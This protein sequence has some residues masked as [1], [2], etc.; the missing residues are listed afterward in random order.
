MSWAVE[1]LYIAVYIH[2]AQYRRLKSMYFMACNCYLSEVDFI[3]MFRNTIMGPFCAD[4]NEE[5]RESLWRIGGG[6]GEGL[7]FGGTI[8]FL[9]MARSMWSLLHCIWRLICEPANSCHTCRRGYD[10]PATKVC[11]VLG[12]CAFP[13]GYLAVDVHA[14]HVRS[15]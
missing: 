5:E 9:Q 1:I 10:G 11:F 15:R 4:R 2:I 6:I 8:L 14:G 12:A 3:S 13:R 7:P